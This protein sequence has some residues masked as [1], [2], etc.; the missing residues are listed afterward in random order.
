MKDCVCI[1]GVVTC[2]YHLLKSKVSELK[3]EVEK[4]GIRELLDN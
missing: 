3:K 1:P 4:L 2:K